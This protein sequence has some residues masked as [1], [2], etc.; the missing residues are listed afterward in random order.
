[1]DIRFVLR[2]YQKHPTYILTCK[3][4]SL[5]DI[6]KNRSKN[7]FLDHN[8]LSLN[9]YGQIKRIIIWIRACICI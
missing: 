9:S 8:P 5:G 4:R 6:I 2:H 7:K 3:E 1:M